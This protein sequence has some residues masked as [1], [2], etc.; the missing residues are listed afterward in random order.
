MHPK[1][2]YQLLTA[3]FRLEVAQTTSDLK[4]IMMDLKRSRRQA[5]LIENL[6]SV[7]RK[8]VPIKTL[9]ILR[10]PRFDLPN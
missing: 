8:G 7:D 9:P 4:S 2:I 5:I 6:K 10:S 1:G 3:A